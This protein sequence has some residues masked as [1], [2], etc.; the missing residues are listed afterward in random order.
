LSS[1]SA[2]CHVYF[3]QPWNPCPE[4][5]T[6]ASAVDIMYSYGR[7]CGCSAGAAR[8]QEKA[9]CRR[10]EYCPW[11]TFHDRGNALLTNL[12]TREA[13]AEIAWKT[14][15]GGLPF[16]STTL[17]P[18]LVIPRS[19][20]PLAFLDLAGNFNRA[21]GTQLFSARL[22]ALDSVL[23]GNFSDHPVLIAR[24]CSV[25]ATLYAIER[26]DTGLY[27]LCSLGNWVTIEALEQLQAASANVIAPKKPRHER[28]D[29]QDSD[30]WRDLAIKDDGAVQL[31]SR[32]RETEIPRNVRLCL[33]ARPA[34]ENRPVLDTL[35]LPL[36]ITRE[37][38][39]MIVDGYTNGAS[40]E[41]S[42]QTTEGLT[43]EEQSCLLP[44]QST[45]DVLSMLR[46][47][48]QENLYISKVRLLGFCPWS[49]DA[50]QGR[51]PWPIL[52]KGHYP[53]REP[54]YTTKLPLRPVYQS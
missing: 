5:A 52:R 26:V 10:Q 7:G 30:W 27:A 16:P 19:C 1:W 39:H 33:K 47:Q 9:R 28:V 22:S 13:D 48:Y 34:A 18:L 43:N 37:P 29:P 15:L 32:R 51:P 6:G 50:D 40:H 42:T 3:E 14:Q 24:A 35:Q 54:R 11:G 17:S 49:D 8:L 12:M 38:I 36:S 53:V 4:T 44:I 46:S 23:Q 20:L 21:P 31:E 25:P 41:P 45:E 2:P